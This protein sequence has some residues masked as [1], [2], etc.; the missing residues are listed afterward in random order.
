MV[1][2]M[3]SVRE[4][5]VCKEK[6]SSMGRKEFNEGYSVLQHLNQIVPQ[7]LRLR[8]QDNLTEFVLYELCCHKGFNIEKA[9]YFVDNPDF[10]CLR[11]IVGF[12]HAEAYVADVDSI[13]DAPEAFSAHMGQ[14]PF[15]QKV[16]GMQKESVRKSSIDDAALVQAMATD[17]G[18]KDYDFYAW[19]MKHDNHGILVFERLEGEP[20]VHEC[21]KNSA[22]LLSFCPLF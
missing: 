10:N 7:M 1:K 15:N 22:S 5:G 11:G 8:D 6:G 18:F 4:S 19:D 13:W 2:R 20:L 9:A 16:R 12:S 3:S 14:A 21:F 17:L